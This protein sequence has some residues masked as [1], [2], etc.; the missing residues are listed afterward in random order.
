MNTPIGIIGYRYDSSFVSFST[1]QFL[2]EERSMISSAGND[3]VIHASLKIDPLHR[4][5]LQ[6]MKQENFSMRLGIFQKNKWVKDI[7]LNITPSQLANTLHV[8]IRAPHHLDKGNYYLRSALQAGEYSASH[9]SEKIS[10][11]VK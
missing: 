2:T 4:L 10:L 5:A 8:L 11:E 6:K 3:L 9:N 1:I 7:L